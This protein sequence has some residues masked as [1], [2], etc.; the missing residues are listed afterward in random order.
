MVVIKGLSFHLTPGFV[1]IARTRWKMNYTFYF[2]AICISS[3][4]IVFDDLEFVNINTYNEKENFIY[5]ISCNNG[6]PEIIKPVVE[7]VKN[8]YNFRFGHE[9]T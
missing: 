8:A 7:F 4:N 9:V 1:H 3:R 6:D 2:R 5:L